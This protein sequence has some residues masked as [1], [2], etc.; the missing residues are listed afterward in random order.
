M[1]ATILG[2]GFFVG[3]LAQVIAGTLEFRKGNTFGMTA[4]TAYGTFWISLAFAVVYKPILLTRVGL[5]ATGRGLAYYLLL[6]GV[7]TL[8]MTVGTFKINRV[9]QFVFIT[10]TVLF[11]MLA[12]GIGWELTGVI[13]AAGIVGLFTGAA[14][15]YL[16][17]AENINEIF[18]K[19]LLPIWPMNVEYKNP[20]DL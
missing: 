18:G 12:I 17:M 19:A 5:E 15:L 13:K 11:G 16:A 10:L 7:F 8:F 20:E 14:A 2:M 1:D 4:F 3:G 6:W 9:L